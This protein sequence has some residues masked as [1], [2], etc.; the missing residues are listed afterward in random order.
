MNI[1]NEE[2]YKYDLTYLLALLNSRY[3]LDPENRRSENDLWNSLE[4][5]QL[6]ETV[7]RMPEGLGEEVYES[8]LVPATDG[9]GYS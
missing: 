6:K 3:S 2:K 7:K 8:V 1:Q 4:I 9:C 5:S